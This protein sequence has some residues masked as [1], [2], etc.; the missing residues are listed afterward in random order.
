MLPLGRGS[1]WRPVQAPLSQTPIKHVHWQQSEE[2]EAFACQRGWFR[3]PR[4]RKA[5]KDVVR[6]YGYSSTGK[7]QC[8]DFL[9]SLHSL[10]EQVLVA[11]IFLQEH[12]QRRGVEFDVFQELL[13][14]RGFVSQGA[15]A[16]CTEFGGASAGSLLAVPRGRGTI[17]CV[18]PFTECDISPHTEP[19]R[20]A[21][22][23][24]SCRCF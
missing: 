23:F 9:S 16:V 6:F 17:G 18:A 2:V 8:L 19:G 12:W 11:S 13:L 10:P 4:V 21:V 24:T 5:R 14:R 22:G 1:E 7:G 20:L 3:K 15:P